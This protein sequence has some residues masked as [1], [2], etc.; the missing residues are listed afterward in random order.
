MNYPTLLNLSNGYLDTNSAHMLPC[1]NRIPQYHEL[2]PE[3]RF[4]EHPAGMYVAIHLASR[5]PLSARV[6]YEASSLLCRMSACSI[7]WNTCFLVTPWESFWDWQGVYRSRSLL[8]A[9]WDLC[10]G[11]SFHEVGERCR[12]L[13]R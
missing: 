8:G 1:N 11:N 7:R 10:V 6:G 9:S 3:C 12:M 2:R 13:A 5:T 4:L